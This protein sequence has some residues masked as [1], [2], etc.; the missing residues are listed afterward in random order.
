MT[1][2]NTAPDTK[3]RSIIIGAVVGSLF[4]IAT[5]AIAAAI[6]TLTA[7]TI[8][9]GFVNVS[10]CDSAYDITADAPSWDDTAGSFLVSAVTVSNLNAPCVGQVVDVEVLNGS[11]NSI[12]SGSGTVAGTNLNLALS[13]S[14]D[15]SAIDAYASVIYTP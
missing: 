8:G 4:A 5:G 13:N 1:D 15:V 12:A 2:Q 9:E 6:V 14:V 7:D 3:K 11:G 10:P